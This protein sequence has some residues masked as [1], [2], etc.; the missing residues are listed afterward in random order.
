M[1]FS[2]IAENR[3]REAMQDGVFDELPGR[4]TPLSLDEYFAAPEELRLAYS[5]LKNA[6]C[7]PPE[8]ELMA[9]LSRIEQALAQAPD[10]ATRQSLQRELTHRQTELAI[11][12]ERARRRQP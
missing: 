4:G 10:A 6:N 2:R 11:L 8:V 3:I 12:K 7:R 1:P 9:E 5:I